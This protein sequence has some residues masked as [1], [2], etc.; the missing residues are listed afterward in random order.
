[1]PYFIHFFIALFIRVW[2]IIKHQPNPIMKYRNIKRLFE[3]VDKALF[4]INSTLDYSRTVEAIAL[5]ANTVREEETEEDVWSIGEFDMATLDSLLIG[6][7][8]F[9]SDYHSG[10]NSDEYAALCAI[11]E[12]FNPGISGGVEEDTT[13]KCVYKAFEDLFNQG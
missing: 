13:E 12:V 9:F 1:M 11:G 4:Y 2:H 10:Q 6:A 8:W 7:Y 3:V 5:L